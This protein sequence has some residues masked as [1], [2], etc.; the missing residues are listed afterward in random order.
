MT[1][2][3]EADPLQAQIEEILASKGPSDAD[4]DSMKEMFAK[5]KEQQD[6]LMRQQ[7]ELKKMTEQQQQR[8]AG[9]AESGV[10]ERDENAGK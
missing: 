6:N 1:N 7:E 2:G 4:R 9:N 3:Q 5:M 10:A 8:M